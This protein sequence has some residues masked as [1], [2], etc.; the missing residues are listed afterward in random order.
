MNILQNVT[1]VV[2]DCSMYL[3]KIRSC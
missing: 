3:F 2:L 1:V